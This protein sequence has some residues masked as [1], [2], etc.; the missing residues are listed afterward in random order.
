MRELYVRSRVVS[1]YA[2]FGSCPDVGV[3]TCCVGHSLTEH[4][5]FCVRLFDMSIQLIY[6]LEPT[7]DA[8]PHSCPRVTQISK[9]A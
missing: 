9:L 3:L 8:L 4:G 2:R 5:L 7:S 1:L 6:S